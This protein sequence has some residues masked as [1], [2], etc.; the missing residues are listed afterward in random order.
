MIKLIAELDG[1]AL[2]I[3]GENFTNL[4]E[5]PCVFIELK[6]SGITKI[7]ALKAALEATEKEFDHEN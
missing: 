1:N 3:H 4:M 5:S 6:E 7:L 2:C